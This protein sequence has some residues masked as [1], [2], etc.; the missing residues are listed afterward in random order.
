MCVCVCVKSLQLCLTLCHPMDCSPP[1]FSVHGILQAKILEWVATPSSRGSPRSWDRTH[2]SCGSCIAGKIFAAE[3]P[4]KPMVA[5][6]RMKIGPSPRKGG[7]SPAEKGVLPQ[8][9]AWISD[10]QIHTAAR[11]ITSR[12]HQ[13]SAPC[14]PGGSKPSGRP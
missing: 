14:L 12:G 2:V 10:P 3:P 5:I 11:S 7:V 9:G 6:I 4:G 1:G 8:R 13:P